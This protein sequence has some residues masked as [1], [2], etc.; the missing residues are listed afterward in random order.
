[1]PT[2]SRQPTDLSQLNHILGLPR[3]EYPNEIWRPELLQPQRATT[4]TSMQEHFLENRQPLTEA[5]YFVE[6]PPADIVAAL[7]ERERKFDT[8][9]AISTRSI[10]ALSLK[11]ALDQLPKVRTEDK[12]Y[13]LLVP[14]ESNWTAVFEAV[15][16]QGADV[17]TNPVIISLFGHCRVCVAAFAKDTS[18]EHSLDKKVKLS[19]GS[20]R[21]DL[22]NNGDYVR[23]IQAMNEGTGRWIFDKFGTPLEHENE[24]AY[25]NRRIKDRF[26]VDDLDFVL[27]QN[28]GIRY[29]DLTFYLPDKGCLVVRRRLKIF[30]L[31]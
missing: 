7:K 27:S 28:F 21:F 10:K 19:L 20:T 8:W 13:F 25:K 14:T 17:N 16:K 15:R 5:I 23:N 22:L 29:R 2:I 26:T 3:P 11:S 12:G 30:G 6:L 24:S 18:K 31:F 4:E 9:Q 1:M